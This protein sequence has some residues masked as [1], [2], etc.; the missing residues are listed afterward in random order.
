MEEVQRPHIYTMLRRKEKVMAEVKEELK[1][2][3]FCGNM[4]EI[5]TFEVKRLF[6]N[7]KESE[8]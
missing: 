5:E 7:A 2:C 6:R 3:P 8:R 4:A 1:P